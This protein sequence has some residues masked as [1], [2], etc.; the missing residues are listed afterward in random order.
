MDDPQDPHPHD[1]HRPGTPDPAPVLYVVETLP[2]F[3]G[4]IEGLFCDA[5]D[6]P[7]VMRQWMEWA[8]VGWAGLIDPPAPG[9]RGEL[10][11]PVIEHLGPCTFPLPNPP[12]DPV[13]WGADRPG[14][15]GTARFEGRKTPSLAVLVSLEKHPIVVCTTH[16]EPWVQYMT[17]GDEDLIEGEE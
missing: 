6:V 1:P 13:P 11:K 15:C 8:L 7:G 3:K 2:E 14:Y 9:G 10:G 17:N 16:F 4:R 12:L 5:D